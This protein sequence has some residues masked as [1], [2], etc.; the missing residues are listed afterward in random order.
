MKIRGSSI[1]R[2]KSNLI[3]LNARNHMGYRVTE[4]KRKSPTPHTHP[5]PLCSCIAIIIGILLIETWKFSLV[6]ILPYRVSHNIV[7]IISHMD[8]TIKQNSNETELYP[9]LYHRYQKVNHPFRS[10]IWNTN[11][12]LAVLSTELIYLTVLP[13]TH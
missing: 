11:Q 8:K 9:A 4:D 13:S 3:D 7:T 10:I 5:H 1:N 6:V 12:N 2:S